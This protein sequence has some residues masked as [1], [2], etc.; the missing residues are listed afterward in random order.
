MPPVENKEMYLKQIILISSKRDPIEKSLTEKGFHVTWCPFELEQIIPVRD[1]SKVLFLCVNDESEEDLNKIC[2][3]LRDMCIEEEKELIIYGKAAG[4]DF[5][6]SRIPA[7]FIR[8][9]A[10]AYAEVLADIIKELKAAA[11]EDD[12]ALPGLLIV[13]DDT[14]YIAK[15]RPYLESH[16]RIYISHAKLN[17]LGA[18][19]YISDVI[20]I[21]ADASYTLFEFLDFFKTIYARIKSSGL[22]FYYLTENDE[23]RTRMNSG[24]ERDAITL[25]KNVD[26]AKT[27]SFLIHSHKG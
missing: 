5:I 25:S 21:N 15:L 17:E 10:Y 7:I 4:V 1:R 19:L 11:N 18:F 8:K 12:N 3:Y 9:K 16:F 23:N 26:V 13:D 14:E 24:S 6:S 22:K 20:L 27:A 2:L